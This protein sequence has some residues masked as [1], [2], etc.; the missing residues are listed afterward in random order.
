M[1]A[2]ATSGTQRFLT[3]SASGSFNSP[4][5][6]AHAAPTSRPVSAKA[7]VSE[8]ERRLLVP[9]EVRRLRQVA[10]SSTWLPFWIMRSSLF[11]TRNS[12]TF[13]FLASDFVHSIV[14]GYPQ[15]R[16]QLRTLVQR[17]FS[18]PKC[19]FL[20]PWQSKLGG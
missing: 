20:K 18:E 8:S 2:G 9:W 6:G 15:P 16:A 7:L 19:L 5:A 3:S 14:G 10:S 1:R 13:A 12:H 4:I 17:A 11:R